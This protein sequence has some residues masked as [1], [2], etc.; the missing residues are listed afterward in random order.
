MQVRVPAQHPR[1]IFH[2]AWHGDVELAYKQAN[3]QHR[4]HIVYWERAYADL[5]DQESETYC[6]EEGESGILSQY[7][8]DVVNHSI[9]PKVVNFKVVL[10]F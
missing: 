9:K 1:V 5:A 10:H 2:G 7:G 6:E 3:K 8:D 4:Q